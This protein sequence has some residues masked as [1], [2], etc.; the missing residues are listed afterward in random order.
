MNK[1]VLNTCEPGCSHML[2]SNLSTILSPVIEENKHIVFLCIGT[3]RAT[4]DCLGPLVGEKLKYRSKS[5][6]SIVGNLSSPVHALNLSDVIKFINTTFSN[7]YIVAIDSALGSAENIGKIFIEEKSLTPGAALSKSLPAVGDLSITGIVNIY[8][9]MEFMTLQST[10]LYTVMTLA[11]KISL[12]ISTC[13]QKLSHSNT[14]N[15][16]TNFSKP[17]LLSSEDERA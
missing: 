5:N 15:F 7:P 6:F 4:G 3:D 13:I 14:F 16:M 17:S 9:A 8:G 11:D 12:G 2:A 1:I 10:R